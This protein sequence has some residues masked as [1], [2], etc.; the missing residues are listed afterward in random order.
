MFENNKE[1][2]LL[3]EKIM[4]SRQ[5]FFDLFNTRDFSEDD[6]NE[7]FWLIFFGKTV[8]IKNT[9]VNIHFVKN[10]MNNCVDCSVSLDE[11]NFIDDHMKYFLF[12]IHGD[13]MKVLKQIEKDIFAFEH[14]S[15]TEWNCE[16]EMILFT[17]L[18]ELYHP[19]QFFHLFHCITD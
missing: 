19:E 4:S 5:L 17:R 15:K 11:I 8:N 13:F 14:T 16:I 18:Q 2:L 10:L 9:D 3:F 1:E 6:V 12:S 7:T